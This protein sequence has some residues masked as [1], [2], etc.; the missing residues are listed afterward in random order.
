MVTPV[1]TKFQVKLLVGL[2]SVII[3]M[4]A[5]VNRSE[6]L[7]LVYMWTDLFLLISYMQYMF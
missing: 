1:I 4:V 2:Q 7:Y 5:Q 3:S 6:A